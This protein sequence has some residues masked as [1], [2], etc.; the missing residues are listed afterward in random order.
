MKERQSQGPEFTINIDFVKKFYYLL[1]SHKITTIFMAAGFRCAPFIKSLEFV[2]HF[3]SFNHYDERS[4]AYMSLQ[5]NKSNPK[6]LSVLICTSGSALSNFYPALL[7][8][9]KQNIPML[10]I[11][12]DRPPYLVQG[13]DN[14]TLDQLNFYGKFCDYFYSIPY[15]S[16]IKEHTFKEIS[17]YLHRF[18]S[19]EPNKNA[20]VH[21]NISFDSPLIVLNH[22]DGPIHSSS[23]QNYKEL[24]S[25]PQLDYS[26]RTLLIFGSLFPH[27]QQLSSTLSF[28]KKI[29]SVLN[30]LQIPYYLDIGSQLKGVCS[31]PWE[32]KSLNFVLKDKEF[33]Q[34]ILIGGRPLS[35]D[36]TLLRGANLFHWNTQSHFCQ[37]THLNLN[38]FRYFEDPW[39]W[40]DSTIPT[41]QSPY[42][43][44]NE[45]KKDD[46]LV[47]FCYQNLSSL[48]S[49]L[50]LGN[51]LICRNFDT[52]LSYCPFENKG[53]TFFPGV[54]LNRGHSGIEGNVASA[55]AM[56]LANKQ[57]K[58]LAVIGDISFLYDLNA[59]ELF[60]K[61]KLTNLKII[62]YNNF[63]GG[64]FKKLEYHHDYMCTP[65]KVNFQKIVEG[66]N[67]G[68]TLIK[69]L[70]PTHIWDQPF[71]I[72]E[73]QINENL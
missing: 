59:L 63:E 60:F 66:F 52:Y 48:N 7:E 71:D 45:W 57:S 42:N 38:I 51:S 55:C 29:S 61:Y 53:L 58:V 23:Y 54:F 27:E 43:F 72:I 25:W 64:I 21:F 50:F 24:S 4:L 46:P 41:V 8:A 13:D 26:K 67:L 10:I 32:V 69:D 20:R 14:Q 22:S 3:K 19:T 28:Y 17:F 49:L 68:F 31:N 15:I 30:S 47:S 40:F 2:P 6:D 65:H 44:S 9:Y 56:A 12:S 62:I 16:Q 18:T 35:K 1:E 34:I 39:K 5:W 36:F 11:S 70:G 73:Y 37:M 33:D